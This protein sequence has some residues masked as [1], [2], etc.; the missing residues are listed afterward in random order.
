VVW[1]AINSGAPGLQGAGLERNLKAIEEYGI[2]YPLLLDEEG[3][4]GRAYAAKT[5]PHMYIIDGEGVLRYA[6]AIDDSNG[7][8]EATRNHVKAALDELLADKPVS[9]TES[10]PYG[11]SVKYAR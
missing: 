6:G 8:G 2:E 4:A 9:V 5:T 1:V 7:R 11:C 3:T 10:K